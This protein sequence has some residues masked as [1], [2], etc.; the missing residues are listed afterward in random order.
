MFKGRTSNNNNDLTM[1]NTNLNNLHLQST[2]NVPIQLHHRY[3]K[4]LYPVV[5]Y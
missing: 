5:W 4:L 2:N 3:P 1:L